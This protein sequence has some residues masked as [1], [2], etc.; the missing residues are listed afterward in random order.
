MFLT[1]EI[2]S[3]E[4]SALSGTRSSNRQFVM[5]YKKC[6]LDENAVTIKLL[7]LQLYSVTTSANSMNV[8]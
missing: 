2:N 6:L 1:I 7:K 4:M 8:W 5:V 3:V